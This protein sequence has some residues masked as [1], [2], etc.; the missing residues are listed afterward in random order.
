MPA[1]RVERRLAAILAA[2]IVGYSRLI[3]QDETGTLEAIRDL[4]REV[5]DPLLA[6]HHGRIVKLMGDG[7]IVEFSSVVEAVACTVA[8]QKDVATRQAEIPPARRIV[9]RIGVN[10]GDVVVEGEDLLGDGVNVA[11]RLEQLCE[12][13][14]VLVSGTA[15]DHLQ[16]RLGLPLEFVGEQRVKNI[17]RPVRA[18]R[19]RVDGAAVRRARRSWRLPGRAVAAA[20][21]ALVVVAAAAGGW[22]W[23]VARDGDGTAAQALPEPP[24]LAVLPFQNLS[25]DERLSRFA[26]GLAADVIADLSATRLLTVIA[27]GTS[28]ASA[29]GPR[30][31]R[32]IG[33][34]LG[35]GYVLDGTLQGDGRQLRATAQLVDATTGAQLWSE[36]FERPLDNLSAVQKDLTQRVANT[37]LGQDSVVFEAAINAAR[38]KP[39][40]DLRP[41][42]IMLLADEQRGLWTKEGNARALELIRQAIA[43]DPRDPAGYAQLAFAYEQQ[44]LEGWAVSD[45][46]AM[47]GWLEAARTAVELD[48]F[49]PSARLALGKRYVWAGDGRAAPELERAAELA[50]G[51]SQILAEAAVDL[52]WLGKTERGLELIERAVRINPTTDYSWAQRW[53][54]FFARRFADAAAAATRNDDPNRISRLVAVLSYAQ[55]G[56]TADAERWRT[57]LWESWPDYSA[58]LFL[59]PGDLQPAAA[60]QRTLFLESHVK[61][62]LPICATPEQ[63][64]QH[65]EIHR[66]PECTQVQ[67]ND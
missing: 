50:P 40:E 28:L 4:R 33:G 51:N 60:A 9:F 45:D 18:Y 13:G 21:A 55:L 38:R 29:S 44:M 32:R 17:E 22:S 23:H 24:S 59:A 53:V 43:L 66:L 56:Q 35:V 52:P 39:A 3:E 30:D 31:A 42:E 67:A 61:A 65:P 12:P 64:G 5:I 26:N 41:R 34:D 49:Y 63:L 58:E 27:P 15:Y 37:L 19:V 8:I 36:R 47:A 2:D 48:P 14:G 1:A 16:G 11:A 54:Y 20:L 57:R 25:A 6:V 10:L 62:E 46:Q 7:A